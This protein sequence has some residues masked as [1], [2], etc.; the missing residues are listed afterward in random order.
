MS[1]VKVKFGAEDENLTRTLN[2]VQRELKQ[3]ETQAGDTDRKVGGGFKSMAGAAA[4]A[5]G[6]F[7]IA[8]TA[9]N[10]IGRAAASSFELM[11]TSVTDASN[12]GESLSKV[13]V[14]FG[15]SS[16]EIVSW[17]ET[18]NTAFGQSK[19]QAMDAATQF[20]TFGKSAGL[21]GKNLTGFS[22]ELVELSADLASF[23]NSTP[24][25]AIEA[26]GSAL[27]GEAE[28]MRRFG[29][30]L[31]DATLRN[32]ALKMGLIAT[33]KEALDPQQKV[34][35]AH[36][37][38]MAQTK[39]AQGDFERTSSGMANQTRIASAN[40]KDLSTK[41][42]QLLLPAVT[43][44]YQAF[45]EYASPAIEKFIGFLESSNVGSWGDNM[46]K[47]VLSISDVLI[48]AF[49]SPM[50]AVEAIGSALNALVRN[51]ASNML[52]AYITS[53][54]F[55]VL[56]FT[57]KLPDLITN[58][59]GNAMF[60]TYAK[61]LEF[62]A[63]GI[64]KIARAFESDWGTAAGKVITFIADGLYNTLKFFASDFMKAIT[65]P[66]AF[67]TGKLS[68]GLADAAENGGLTFKSAFSDGI[69][70]SLDKLSGGLTT[71]ANQ[72][73]DR[74]KDGTGAIKS[75]FG[76]IIELVTPSAK[77]FFGAKEA[78]D[79]MKED[80]RKIEDSG[81]K[82]REDYM[83]SKELTF[84]MTKE[85]NKFPNLTW[86][87]MD[88]LR[89][90]AS[91][92]SDAAKDVKEALS[93]SEEITK[94]IKEMEGKEAVDRGG[95]LEKKANEAIAEGDGRK[96][97]RI[98][99]QIRKK[100]EDAAFNEQFN[101][102]RNIKKSLKDMAKDEGLDI[103]GKSSKELREE[104]KELTKN[105]KKDNNKEGEQKINEKGGGAG[106]KGGGDVM[107]KIK[108][109]VESI[110]ALVAK[111]EPKLPQTALAQ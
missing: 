17:A 52:N 107:E 23:N 65:S 91:A 12:I 27:R 59:V 28:P 82:V 11:K 89:V 6:A 60:V 105:L 46:L 44:V 10:A 45:N 47:S 85:F 83:K 77:N 51:H 75:E 111:I 36:A 53:G 19:T 50:V 63:S 21:M 26:I 86:N 92:M 22:R 57:S 8:T 43:K 108:T 88:H 16:S 62:L 56:F 64:S 110:Q 95:K 102:G 5:G 31:D 37:V 74:L 67:I 30:L 76:K 33:T 32:Q 39:D 84:D 24:E 15:K 66:M 99:D 1:D 14:I 94:R 78:T 29:V 79:S 55:L 25:E 2:G 98:N 72:Y 97:E 41:F 100:E 18:S 20:A 7:A 42:G 68:S 90:G 34:L 48:G 69:A 87:M 61:S 106:G 93:L 38:I 81:K 80:F 54:E 70:T 49:T 58:Q 71:T 9:I 109:A 4:L 104:L 103:S 3:V 73:S 101:D 35:A 96:A 13:N 40:I